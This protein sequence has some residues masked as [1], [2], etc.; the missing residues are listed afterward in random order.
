LVWL[1]HDR[2]HIVCST[3]TMSKMK[4]KWLRVIEFE[5][6]GQPIDEVTRQ[7]LLETHPDLPLLQ[8]TSATSTHPMDHR[9]HHSHGLGSAI[10][11]ESGELLTPIDDP[12]QDLPQDENSNPHPFD[13][14]QPLPSQQDL[15]LHHTPFPE[16]ELPPDLILSSSH[17]QP[18]PSQPNHDDAIQPDLAE[19]THTLQPPDH[20]FPDNQIDLSISGQEDRLHSP[21][22]QIDTRL[23]RRIHDEIATANAAVVTAA[24]AVAV[25]DGGR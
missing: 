4:R 13:Q 17:L 7:Q 23:E 24:A 19:H 20:I 15:H 9:E 11:H 25:A 22:P 6:S 5:E 14:Q 12:S 8:G 3:T 18:F 2:F 21:P 10:N 1:I 16:Q